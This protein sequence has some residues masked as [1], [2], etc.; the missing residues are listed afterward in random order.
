MTIK[1]IAVLLLML[2]GS[3][4][5]RAQ[6]NE[7]IRLYYE[8]KNK[9]ELYV[10]DADYV[11]ALAAYKKAFA[12]KKPNPI[13][14]YNAFILA[15][16]LKDSAAAKTF[17]TDIILHGQTRQKLEQIIFFDNFK[18]DPFYS[19]VVYGY[20]SIASAAQNGIMPKYAK[21]LDS[22][23]TADQA[24][25]VG[26]PSQAQLRAMMH[27]DSVNID[28]IKE[29]VAQNGFPDYDMVGVFERAKTGVVY[30]DGTIWMLLWHTR[31]I[32]K[33]LNNILLQAVYEGHFSPDEYALIIDAQEDQSIYYNILLRDADLSK[34]DFLPTPDETE[35]NKK[36]AAIMLDTVENF[37]RKLLYQN[38][39]GHDF[40]LVLPWAMIANLA[41]VN[42]RGW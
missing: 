2:T 7:K 10:V 15:C 40:Y 8:L 30:G 19:Y 37:K 9:A 29:F 32:S 42:I 36:R 16:M 31:H 18:A 28:F 11:Q 35:V 12:L 23:Y 21:V 26:N 14:I 13:D 5:A 22:I 33:E 34:V 3:T 1:V 41:P 20:D 24:V 17:F 38:Q 39:K 27:R 25:R 4:I 6:P